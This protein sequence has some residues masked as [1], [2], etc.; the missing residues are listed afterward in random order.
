MGLVALLNFNENDMDTFLNTPWLLPTLCIAWA[1]VLV[2][3]HIRRETPLFFNKHSPMPL[4][5][6]S[7]E[8]KSSQESEH[9]QPMVANLEGSTSYSGAEVMPYAYQP[10][11]QPHA[12]ND[13]V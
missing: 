5:R 8:G 1:I 4:R 6:G 13:Y 7:R 9:G 2:L 3:T 10:A 12:G 11:P